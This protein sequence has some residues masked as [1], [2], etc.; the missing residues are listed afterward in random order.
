M[1]ETK[2]L[3][4]EDINKIVYLDHFQPKQWAV[5]RLKLLGY[6]GTQIADELDIPLF[7][8]YD[9]AMEIR[10]ILHI[11]G[12]GKRRELIK[13]AIDNGLISINYQ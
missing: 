2:K 4:L 9:R 10:Q 13:W 12:N 3:S 1:A 5:L 8:A 7:S 11:S 6:T